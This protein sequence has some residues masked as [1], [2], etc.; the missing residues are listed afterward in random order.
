GAQSP[1]TSGNPVDQLPAAQPTSPSQGNADIRILPPAQPAQ[2]AAARNVTPQR[3]A[4]EGVNAI[5]FDEVA[6]LFK[7]LA[8]KPT[9]VGKVAD[10]AREVSALYRQRGYALSFC[11]IPEQDFRDGVVRVVAVEGYIATLNIEGDAGPAEP[12]VREIAE[13]IRQ[14]RPLQLAT[15]ERYTQLLAQLP[16]LKVEATATPPTRTDGAGSMLLKVSHKPFSISAATDIRSSRPRAV[17]TGVLN[18]PLVP[19]GRLSAS[20]LV[21]A[22]PGESFMAAGYSQMVGSEGLTLKAEASLYRGDPDAQLDVPPAIRR[23]TTYKRAELS[24]SY[25]LKLTR[26]DSLFLSG[27]VYA[28][29]NADDYAV[30][31]SGVTLKDDVRVRAVYLQASYH[32]ATDDHA[33]SLLLRFAQGLNSLGATKAITANVPGPLP[34]NPARLD[35]SR[36][37]LEGSRRDVWAKKWGT[38]VSF[39]T[40]YSPNT[41]PATERIS[42]GSGRFGR[43]YA[44]G[45][46]AGDSGWGL[47][48]EASRSFT[49]DTTYLKQVQPYVLF[50]QAQVTNNGVATAFSRL[51]S[52]SIG[53]RISDGK[54]YSIDLAAS[55]PV[56]DAAP[57]NPQRKIRLST[58]VSY[59]FEA[60]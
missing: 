21:G 54:Y 35:F 2:A 58:I 6:A 41:L 17:V 20:T 1:G 31:A 49:L 46:A 7:P 33:Q 52:A 29:N 37:L 28:T 12:K 15:F 25:P 36:V 19:G 18:D 39:A 57:D 47:A 55:K 43:A 53:F 38:A 9:T 10:V 24:A 40:Q 27:G 11:F 22:L 50:E 45:S 23:Y 8:G 59:N 4:I 42:F 56:G 32:Q 34:V 14:D 44:A 5:P 60:R 16:G 51:S 3:F 26:S 13:K 48:L 30:P